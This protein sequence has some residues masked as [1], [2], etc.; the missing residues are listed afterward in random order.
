MV[1]TQEYHCSSGLSSRLSFADIKGCTTDEPGLVARGVSTVRAAAAAH[2]PGAFTAGTQ[3]S[4]RA[5][6]FLH[7][8][9]PG[10][11]NPQYRTLGVQYSL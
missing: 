6:N 7:K 1:L 8:M 2:F 9:Q 4:T 3:E 11:F 10:S 5:A